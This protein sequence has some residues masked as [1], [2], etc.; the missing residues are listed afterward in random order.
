MPVAMGKKRLEVDRSVTPHAW[1]KRRAGGV[2]WVAVRWGRIGEVDRCGRIR[3]DAATLRFT[4]VWMQTCPQIWAGMGLAGCAKDKKRTH[5]PFVS[6]RWA[7][8]T[9]TD[10][11]GAFQTKCVGAL[12]LP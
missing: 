5:G 7:V 10:Q 4:S 6:A 11:N 1:I 9:Q 12:E 8:Y 3:P 2:G